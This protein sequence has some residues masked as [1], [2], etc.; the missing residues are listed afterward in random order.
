MVSS[1]QQK[2][3]KMTNISRRQFIRISTA[4]G[5][6]VLLTD[7]APGNDATALPLAPE[8]TKVEQ[9][10]A[11]NAWPLET[12]PRNQTLIF[13]GGYSGTPSIFNPLSPSYNHQNGTAVLYEPCAYYHPLSG[14]T[15]LWLAESCQYN[16]DA[17][18]LT[19]TFRNGIK[20]SDGSTFTADDAVWTITTLKN[21]G[22]LLNR[23]NIA[24]K[25]VSVTATDDRTI[26]ITL[27]HTD[28]RFFMNVFITAMIRGMSRL[29]PKVCSAPFPPINWQLSHFMIRR[30]NGRS[31]PGRMEPA[32]WLTAPTRIM[33]CAPPG[34]RSRPAWYNACRRWSDTK[35][36]IL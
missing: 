16:T 8:K 36:R 22:G 23:G 17:T 25:V 28:W 18:E 34:G 26:K 14:S 10:P 11:R 30:S 12:V 32:T 3:E 20:W 7:L 2:G 35:G 27:N 1:V 33:T 19:I 4:T 6:G 5:L 13:Y 24:E 9:V 15:I 21:V 29:S 31:A